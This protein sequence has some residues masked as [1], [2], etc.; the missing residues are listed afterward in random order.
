MA[1]RNVL[2]SGRTSLEAEGVTVPV[3][4]RN[5]AMLAPRVLDV[6]IVAH[7]CEAALNVQ[8]VRGRRWIEEQQMLLARGAV[9]LK[10]ADAVDA[11]SP[12]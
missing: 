3:V 10:D 12:R 5:V 9:V 11:D 1:S 7:Q 2:E 6:E 8:R 4:E